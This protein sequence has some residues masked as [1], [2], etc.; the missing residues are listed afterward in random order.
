M[1]DTPDTQVTE[2]YVDGHRSYRADLVLAPG[3][4]RVTKTFQGS[5]DFLSGEAVFGT[6][7][8]GCVYEGDNRIGKDELKEKIIN[9]ARLVR[10]QGDVCDLSLTYTEEQKTEWWSLDYA[11]INKDIRNWKANDEDD[12]PDLAEIKLWENMQS[13]NPEAYEKLW[14]GEKEADALTGNTKTLALKIKKG[15]TYY[16][17]HAPILTRSTVL[18]RLEDFAENVPKLD[19]IQTPASISKDYKIAGG[20]TLETFTN[21]AKK[22]LLS[23]ARLTAN[24]DGTFSWLQ[25]WTGAD[26]I[27]ADLY[28]EAVKEG[29]SAPGD[30]GSG[31]EGGKSA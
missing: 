28:D 29:G 1:A 14:A 5:W 9:G 18:A 27:D 13:I 15:V 3:V 31:D 20:A 11:T 16:T 21:L 22:W 12:P 24:T 26:E 7:R 2:H 8:L 19:T 4:R 17:I 30:G 23:M 25:Q 10:S 6:L